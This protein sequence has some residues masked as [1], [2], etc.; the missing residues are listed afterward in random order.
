MFKA[1]ALDEEEGPKKSSIAVQ[2]IRF[3]GIS[4]QKALY[5]EFGDHCET[6]LQAIADGM[7]ENQIL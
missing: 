4:R 6:L 7:T 1:K 3:F 5:Y 2:Q